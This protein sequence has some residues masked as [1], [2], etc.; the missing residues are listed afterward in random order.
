MHLRRGFAAMLVV[1]A[2]TV[3]ASFAWAGE[4]KLAVAALK[5]DRQ[6]LVSDMAARANYFLFFDETGTLLETV[7]NPAVDVSGHAGSAVA[8]FLHSKGVTVFI[9]GRFGDRLQGA[10]RKHAIEYS[11]QKGVV[12][13]V[14][15]SYFKNR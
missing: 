13:D 9:A 4:V 10:L 15:K 8:D 5:P 1:V 6:S 11:E 3:L 14:V 12:D 7:K 2:I